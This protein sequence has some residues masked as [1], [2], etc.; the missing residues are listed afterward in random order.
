[1][2][3]ILLNVGWEYFTPEY[4]EFYGKINFLKGGIVCADVIS[5]VSRKYGEEIQTPEFGAGLDGVLRGRASDLYG[6]INGVDYD[7]WSPD[8]DAYI[9]AKFTAETIGLKGQNKTALQKAFGLPANSAAML[10]ASISRLADQ[11][12]FDLIAD[13]PGR[14]GRF[15][16]AVCP[17]RNR[18][19]E[20][21][22]ALYGPLR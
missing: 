7:D 9:P 13:C 14:D 12:G 19:T 16:H 6:I 3:C 22:R 8:R 1:M 18:G 4:L 20:I 10:V 2:I 17:S 5:T 15:G 21:P 11:K